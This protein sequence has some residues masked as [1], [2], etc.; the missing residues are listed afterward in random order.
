MLRIFDSVIDL[1][2]T[3]ADA[4]EEVE[5]LRGSKGKEDAPEPGNLRK[6]Q[7]IANGTTL[8]LSVG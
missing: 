1:H 5:H 6:D 8:A 7:N 4:V 2:Y 3:D